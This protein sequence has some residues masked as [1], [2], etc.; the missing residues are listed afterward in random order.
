LVVSA[1]ALPAVGDGAD[2]WSGSDLVETLGEPHG[3]ELRSGVGVAYTGSGEAIRLAKASGGE[4]LLGDPLA[5]GQP[6][7]MGAPIHLSTD[8]PL[9]TGLVMDSR[10]LATVY[11]RTPITVEY[12]TIGDQCQRNIGSI[13]AEERL[14]FGLKR[15]AAA[16]SVTG[17]D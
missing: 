11:N 4:Y 8:V 15:P 3:R 7:L 5:A 9:G 13:R 12:G 17:L 14:A 6:T 16:V 2:R 10:Q 1:S